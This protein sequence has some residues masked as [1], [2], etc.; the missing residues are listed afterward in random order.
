MCKSRGIDL[1]ISPLPEEMRLTSGTYSTTAD[2]IGGG[3][4]PIFSLTNECAYMKLVLAYSLGYEQDE[5]LPFIER[6]VASE[7][8]EH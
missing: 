5:I 3:V 2:L 1:F 7:K 8:L 6:E 4:K